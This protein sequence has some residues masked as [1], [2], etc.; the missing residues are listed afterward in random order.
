[1]NIFLDLLQFFIT[2]TQGINNWQFYTVSALDGAAILQKKTFMPVS[3]SPLPAQRLDS[4]P[5]LWDYVAS[6]L[7]LCYHHWSYKTDKSILLNSRDMIKIDNILKLPTIYSCALYYKSFMIVIY[8]HNDS[9]IIEPV[10]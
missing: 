3:L 5:L 7:P 9:T 4:N 1:M 10:L 8:N 6:V 2:L